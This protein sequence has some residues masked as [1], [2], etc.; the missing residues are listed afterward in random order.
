MYSKLNNGKAD[1]RIHE[2][3]INT[4]AFHV[5]SFSFSFFL[6]YYVCNFT[7]IE[8][9]AMPIFNVLIGIQL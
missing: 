3:D 4:D 9:A 7:A 5:A 6:Y 8:F 2:H 1:F